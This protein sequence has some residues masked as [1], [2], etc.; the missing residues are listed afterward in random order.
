M[1]VVL[2]HVSP[3]GLSEFEQAYR[4]KAAEMNIPFNYMEFLKMYA[5]YKSGDEYILDLLK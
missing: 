4:K 2:G 1:W 3:L 5:A